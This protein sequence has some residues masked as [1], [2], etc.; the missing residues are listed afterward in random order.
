MSQNWCNGG[1]LLYL[2]TSFACFVSG[3]H[4]GALSPFLSTTTY[5]TWSSIYHT[6]CCSLTSC[7][8][9][10]WYWT[11]CAQL[12]IER[13]LRSLSLNVFCAAC[14]WT[15]FAQLVIERVLRSLSLNV[16]CAACHWT[17]FAQLVSEQ[18]LCVVNAAPCEITH[19]MEITADYRTGFTDKMRIKYRWS[20][21]FFVNSGF[22]PKFVEHVH[23]NMWHHWRTSNRG[24]WLK[25]LLKVKRL[26]NMMN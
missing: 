15:C 1:R 25:V 11:C 18:R 20:S 24:P 14:H 2:N 5:F 23:M 12:V 10:G 26:K 16:F 22:G 6:D 3:R 7:T 4:P 13:V 17:C 21:S 9:P 19:V 8:D